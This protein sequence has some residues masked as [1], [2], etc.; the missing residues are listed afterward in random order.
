[1]SSPSADQPPPVL[2]GIEAGATR[3]V[4]LAIGGPAR[5]TTRMEFAGANLCL[6]SDAQLLHH[7]RTIAKAMPTPK[8]LGIGMAGAA[9]NHIEDLALEN[10]R[11]GENRNSREPPVE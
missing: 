1:M 8:F 4:T 5:R 6:L 9:H 2:L 3:T 7:L 10:I 11:H